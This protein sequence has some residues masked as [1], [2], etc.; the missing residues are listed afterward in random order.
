MGPG[1]FYE[2]QDAGGC[3]FLPGHPHPAG[4]LGTSGYKLYLLIIVLNVENLWIK[5]LI[6]RFMPGQSRK[7]K[8]TVDNRPI[9]YDYK[10]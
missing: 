1:E 10:P 3:S 5:Q 7:K 4:Q 2:K 9:S 8:G 6:R